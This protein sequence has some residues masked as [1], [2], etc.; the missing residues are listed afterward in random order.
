MDPYGG[1]GAGAAYNPYGSAAM[2]GSSDS[3][4]GAGGAY[5]PYGASGMTSSGMTSSSYASAGGAYNPYG[6]AG[7]ADYSSSSYGAGMMGGGYGAAG[8][9]M[10]APAAD[11]KLF[12]FYDFMVEPE[13]NYK[14]RVKLYLR[15]PN[16]PQA[17]MVG[18]PAAYLEDTVVTRVKDL[19]AEDAKKTQESGQLFQTFWR[20]T[21]WSEWSASATIP[22]QEHA[23]AGPVDPG[24]TTIVQQ[25]E[26]TD[27][28]EEPESSVLAMVFDPV[29]A[30]DVPGLVSAVRG[31]VLNFTGPANVLH[32]INFQVFPLKE[33]PFQTDIVVLDMRGGH[34]LPTTDKANID[35]K[36]P[37][38]VLLLDSE[39]KLV[40]RN[41]LDDLL[42]YTNNIFKE[43]E[44]PKLPAG[45]DG[46]GM[47]PGYPGSSSSAII[48]YPGAGGGRSRGRGP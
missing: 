16:H 48:G 23:L 40:V 39:G 46:E 17:P 5:N 37:G 2:P 8:T 3:Y 7:S 29:K 25:I 33:Y 14:Y 34:D 30:A 11:Y 18:P 9:Q 24:R 20:E 28:G 43:P 6:A 1:G 35:H 26:L 22:A 4:G 15:D 19:D 42:D 13:K 36:A 31:T 38:E 21:D 45:E 32:P 12:R 10:A 27:P 44:K 47:Y 41:E